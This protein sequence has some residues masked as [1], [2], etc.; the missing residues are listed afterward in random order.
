MLGKLERIVAWSWKDLLRVGTMYS[1]NES[2][3]VYV[4]ATMTCALRHIVIADGDTRD[5]P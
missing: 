1:C 4:Y 2:I 3:D 5:A